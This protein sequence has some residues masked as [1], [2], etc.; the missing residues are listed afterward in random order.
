MRSSSSFFAKPRA[1]FALGASLLL[2]SSS[3]TVALDFEKLE[4][5][6]QTVAKDAGESCVSIHSTPQDS[7]GSGVIVSNEGHIFS[8]AHVVEMVGEVVE[9]Y[10]SNGTSHQATVE[11]L[12]FDQ[13]LALLK[14]VSYRP[15]PE[16]VAVC[17]SQ[18]MSAGGACVAMG[19]AYG[20]D[21]ERGAPV[22]FGLFSHESR[23]GNLMTTC[24]VAAGDSGGPLFNLEGELIAIHRTIDAG[25]RFTAHIP[26][27]VF[28]DQFASAFI[29]EPILVASL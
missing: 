1:Q 2:L 27:K 9:I 23:R 3:A 26:V 10:F 12:D 5:Q 28:A 15:A 25:G 16:Q 29:A 20:F 18:K 14:F 11:A 19:H 17:A 22:R 21:Q 8:A 24:R 7:W 13:D 6:I 4:G